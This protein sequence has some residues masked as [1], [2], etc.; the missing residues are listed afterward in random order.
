MGKKFRELKAEE[1]DVRIGQ[2]IATPKWEGVSLLLYKNARVDM[3]ILDETVGADYW[4]RDHKV[5]NDNLYCAVGIWNDTLRDW[6]WKT[7]CGVESNTEKE[8]GEAS[9]AFKRACV[10][11]GIGRELYTAPKNMLIA[12]EL[13]D[14]KKKPKDKKLKFSVSEI[15]YIDGRITR[16]IVVDQNNA[17]AFTYPKNSNTTPQN[18]PANGSKSND[19]PKSFQPLTKSELIGFY[20]IENPEKTIV[21][22]EGKAGKELANF[23]EEETASARALLDKKKAERE[24]EAA[25]YKSQLK[26]I[27]DEEL[28]FK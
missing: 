27:S 9:D 16:L 15:E 22:L 12:C 11:W 4:Q 28:P 25:R 17:V 24:A 20:G 3:D 8:K 13:D 6:V 19:K 14:K 18:K 5:I 23:N 10:N 7:D 2:C 1:I 21:W 26:G